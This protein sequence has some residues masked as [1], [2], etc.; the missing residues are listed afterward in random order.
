MPL[1]KPQ[2]L[3]LYSNRFDPDEHESDW[4]I[5]CNW[6]YV[7]PK[8]MEPIFDSKEI[9][10]RLS[11]GDV[12]TLGKEE[13]PGWFLLI[14]RDDLIEYAKP[15]I[16]SYLLHYAEDLAGQDHEVGIRKWFRF[17]EMAL[18]QLWI[19][20]VAATGHS[21]GLGETGDYWQFCLDILLESTKDEPEAF[22]AALQLLEWIRTESY[23]RPPEAFVA[24]EQK[25]QA[26]SL[27]RPRQHGKSAY[28]H[29][30]RDLHVSM[31]IYHL[32]LAGIPPTRNDETDELSGADVV[33]DVY[34][35][36]F[37]RPLSYEATKAIW[38]RYSNLKAPLSDV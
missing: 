7:D 5:P 30:G 33:S 15:S 2:Q 8:S 12:V 28:S 38:K 29:W 13:L 3:L 4:F 21:L 10:D 34:S 18:T 1:M 31:A 9:W 11:E 16:Q 22:D 27:K 23:F 37:K 17:G 19:G 35:T 24:W 20:R 26:G 32:E 36:T 14:H 25:V 6:R